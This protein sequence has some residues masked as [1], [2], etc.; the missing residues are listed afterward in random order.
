[1]KAFI[2]MNHRIRE[3]KPGDP[4]IVHQSR[5]G[6]QRASNRLKFYVDG[7]LIGE[8]RFSPRGNRAIDSHHVRAWV[9]LQPC[10]SVHHELPKRRRRA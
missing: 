9:E 3:A 4:V 5:G 10:V 7:R 8:V 6:L 1:M 2:F